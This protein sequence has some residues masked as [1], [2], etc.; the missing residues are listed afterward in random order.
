VVAELPE[1][2]ELIVRR[3]SP[4]ALALNAWPSDR[5]L[6]AALRKLG[7]HVR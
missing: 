4:T 1:M 7:V 2:K 6:L 3:I 5:G